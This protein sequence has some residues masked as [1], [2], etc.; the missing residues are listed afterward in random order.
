MVNFFGYLFL[1]FFSIIFCVGGYIFLSVNHYRVR[2]WTKTKAV[3]IKHDDGS[4]EDSAVYSEIVKFKIN[5]KEFIARLNVQSSFPRKIGKQIVILYDPN[6]PESYTPYSF[7]S[8]YA[9]PYAFLIIGVLSMGL[10][11]YVIL[12]GV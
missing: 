1:F 4:D 11:V 5:N 3:I 12:A 10:I 6:N 9:A 7:F 8:L 2:N